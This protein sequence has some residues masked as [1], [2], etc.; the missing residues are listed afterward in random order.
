MIFDKRIAIKFVLAVLFCVFVSGD[1]E[2]R[3]VEREREALLSFKNGLIYE[4]GHLSS[5]Q[6]NEC[7]KW[8]GV[9]CSNATG[10][11]ISL[12]LNGVN[13]RGKI[14]SSLLELHHLNSLGLSWNDFGGIPIPE[15]IG[16]MKQ[17]QHLYLRSSNFSGNVPPQIGNLT[18]LRSLDLS[19]NSLRIE[20]LDWLSSLSVLS[21]LDLSHIDLS[22][23]NLLEQVTS[24][25][26][27][28]E[29]H[30]AFCNI[31]VVKHSVSHRSLTKLRSLDLSFNSLSHTSIFIFA[32]VLESLEILNLEY[33]QLNG[34]IPDLRAFS[35]LKELYLSGNNLTG[36]IP[37]SIG[38]LSELQVLD[39]SYNSL[40]GLVSESHFINLDKLKTLDL[41]FNQ[42]MLDIA[43][44]WSP[45]FQLKT[46]SLAGCSVGP[47]FPKWIGTQRNLSSLDVHGANITDE[48]PSGVYLGGNMFNGSLSS[49][50]ETHHDNL[51]AL[52]LS[53]NQLAGE[54]PN[55][56]EK[57][58]NLLS[59]NLANNTFSGEIPASLGALGYIVALQMHGNNLSGELP[60]S[61]ILCQELRLI[62]VGGNMLTGEIPTWIGHMYKMLFLNLR[63]N[64]LHGSIPSQICNLIRIQVLDLSINKLDSIIPD[65]FNN[66]TA[67][68]STNIIY[69]DLYLF[70]T[71]FDIMDE[72][73]Q[74]GYSSF[75]WK[76]Q[77]LEYKKNL[78]LLKLIDFSSNR[79]IGNI[80]KSFSDMRGLNSLNLS[81]N[82]L[83]GS[84]IPDIGQ[85]DM[86]NSLDLSHNRLSGNIPTSLAEIYS[87][88]FLDLSNNNLSG[89]I[90]AST[91]LQS[92]NALAYAEND[93]LCGDPLPKCPEDSLKP[94]ATSPGENMNE[95]NDI[96]FSF[97]QGFG[98]S[99]AFGFV[100][101]F[102]GSCWFILQHA[103]YWS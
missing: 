49:I 61:M 92:F 103:G 75:Q 7:C 94:H 63:G 88:G 8:Y 22:H 69:Y 77:Q 85:M 98:L 27:L 24:L 39:L 52:T 5:W 66:F 60:Y 21:Y 81:G 59:L 51:R 70:G 26:F 74:G 15:F 102:W 45:P 34:S 4:H 47:Y 62:D 58:P 23:A 19:Y 87:L 90:P 97:M 79:L 84:I 36:S 89:K 29:L 55:C 91:Q 13:L 82:S 67:L 17:L 41:S 14:G 80:P 25:Q 9:E 72:N 44:D 37:L 38:Q 57:M 30:L 16:S 12:Q 18:N 73:K 86:L 28:H 6:S 71:N 64:K 78:G 48:A 95:N 99:M 100:F 43:P 11:V 83:T 40:E 53:N 65:C 42:L 31:S 54:V 2:V 68:A 50:C 101:G 33:N 56:W 10:H 32:S 3:C 1:S 46:I 20:N 93:G 96:D 76:G 35:S